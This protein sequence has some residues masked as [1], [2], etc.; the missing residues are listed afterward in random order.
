MKTLVLLSIFFCLGF[1]I[2][3]QQQN[4]SYGLLNY[5]N[6]D[7]FQNGQR[8]KMAEVIRITAINE[9]AQDL[10]KKARKNRNLSLMTAYPGYFMIGWG[11]GGLLSGAPVEWGWV[12][13]G[14]GLAV[15]SFFFDAAF[16]RNARLTTE[17]FNTSIR[18]SAQKNKL[19]LAL[20]IQRN[21]LGVS[22]NF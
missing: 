1:S 13:A 22:I 8:I 7:F 11:L 6:G 3:A 16:D 20:G 12:G 4:Q 21:G 10:A 15:G 18:S 5:Q 14:T 9:E 2:Q 17:L 19:E